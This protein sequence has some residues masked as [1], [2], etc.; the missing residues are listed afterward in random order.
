MRRTA[1]TLLLLLP[2]GS[3][4]AETIIDT[5]AGDGTAG[6]SGDGGPARQAQ[7]NQPFHCELDGK[8]GLYI[9]EAFNHCI[10]KVDLKSGTITTVAG[11]GK[12][13]Y[14]GDGGPATQATMNEPYAMA[15][16]GNGDLYIVDRLNAVIRKVDGKT[17]VISTVAGNGKKGY[18][19]DGGPAVQASL[20]EPNDCCLDRQG[21]LLIADVADWRVRRVDLKSGIIRTFAGIGRKPNVSADDL[22]E[23]QPADKTLLVG[24]RAVCADTHGN[25]YICLREGH[26]LRVVRKTGQVFTVAGT[27]QPGYADVEP[28]QATFNGP[29]AI[30]AD[31]ANDI[32]IVDTENHA[33]RRYRPQP[34]EKILTIAG[35]K[36]GGSGDGGDATMAGLDRPHGVAID[37]D[38]T[39]YIADS[40]NHRIRR[41]RIK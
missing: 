4:A 25:I 33:I 2:L 18:S 34:G 19:G 24:P 16:D 31:S 26:A 11:N 8:G 9:A 36:K 12:K 22:R 5:V 14:S 28:M 17:G 15:L 3:A 37:R 27:G 7:L 10:R 1:L 23:G 38:G 39:L 41:V 21:G 13:G 6:Y 40:N 20:R 35:G 29:K 32:Y 30:R